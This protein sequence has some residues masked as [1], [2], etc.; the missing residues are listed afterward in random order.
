MHRAGRDEMAAEV[1]DNAGLLAEA[2]VEAMPA[3]RP[4][5]FSGYGA[6][7]RRRCLEDTQFHLEHLAAALDVDDPGE[8]L[9]YRN[10]LS[11]VLGAH[12]VPEGGH[13]RQLCP[14]R[15]RPHR[16]VRGIGRRRGAASR[17]AIARGREA[18]IARTRQRRL[19]PSLAWLR[20]QPERRC[21]HPL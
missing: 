6:A 19:R 2:V 4:D 1:R 5:M 3:A 13:R 10:W 17:S 11:V 12:G 7:G 15:L 16:A 14:D 9:A 21:V 8:F 18:G 20:G